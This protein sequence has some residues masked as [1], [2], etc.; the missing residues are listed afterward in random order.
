MGHSDAARADSQHLCKPVA[1]W[2]KICYADF[3]TIV[4]V[5]IFAFYVVWGASYS[6]RMVRWF[7]TRRLSREHN[8]DPEAT[9]VGTHQTRR[10]LRSMLHQHTARSPTLS[11]QRFMHRSANG[12]GFVPPTDF[13]HDLPPSSPSASSDSSNGCDSPTVQDDPQFHERLRLARFRFPAQAPLSRTPQLIDIQDAFSTPELGRRGSQWSDDT[14]DDEDIS[15]NPY[16][17]HKHGSPSKGASFGMLNFE[18]AK[19]EEEAVAQRGFKTP[20]PAYSAGGRSEPP[21]QT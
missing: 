19:L 7:R 1:P 10:G 16:W 20:P 14:L 15:F 21:R 17:T 4:C 8:A 12:H 6:V 2:L 5:A 9:L 18:D 11:L 13:L 3:I